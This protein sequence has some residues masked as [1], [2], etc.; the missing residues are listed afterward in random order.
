[1][2]ILRY[3]DKIFSLARFK[4]EFSLQMN[5]HHWML[6]GRKGKLKAEEITILSDQH[7]LNL[8]SI[9]KKPHMSNW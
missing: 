8:K 5:Q 3:A 9:I 7:K 1:M 2:I 4:A 6:T